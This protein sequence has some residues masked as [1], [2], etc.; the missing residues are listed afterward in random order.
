M[1]FLSYQVIHQAKFI[2]C[3]EQQPNFLILN[4]IG[5]L[6]KMKPKLEQYT[7]IHLHMDRDKKGIEV[8]K[9]ALAISNKYRDESTAYEN[10][11]DLNEY[12]MK[13]QQEAKQSQSRS[14]KLSR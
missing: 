10:Y 13:E 11:K 9:D 8:T 14:R 3:P 5:F 6:E 1:D 2:L 4:S 7:S 12:L